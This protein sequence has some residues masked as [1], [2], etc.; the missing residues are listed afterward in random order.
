MGKLTVRSFI[1]LMAAPVALPVLLFAIVLV[2]QLDRREEIALE[3]RTMRDVNAIASAVGLILSDMESTLDL[4]A[5]APDLETGN[6]EELYFRTQRSLRDTGKFVIVVDETGRQLL[7]TRVPYDQE[8]GRTSDLESLNRALSSGETVISDVFFGQ[9]SGRHVF[10]VVKPLPA[11]EKSPARAL[12]ITKNAQELA[13]AF[14]SQDLPTGWNI[15]VTDRSGTLLAGSAGLGVGVGTPLDL[16]TDTSELNLRGI[17]RDERSNTLLGYARVPLSGWYAFIWGPIASAKSSIFA[18]WQ[19]LL[20]AGTLTL[21]LL[22]AGSMYA[23]GQLRKAITTLAKMARSVGEGNVVSPVRSRIREI[24]M[25][26]VALSEASFDRSEAEE[27]SRVVMHELAH[28]TKNLLAV[29]NSI[30]RQTARHSDSV[31][32]MQTSLQARVI[33]LA[34]S[35]DLL[36]RG[37][38]GRVSLRELVETQR[39]T[40]S[41]AAGSVG[42]EGED[43]YLKPDAAQQ[44]GM[45][46]HE[47]S[48][49]AIKYGA[50]SVPQGRVSISWNVTNAAD[51]EPTL[52]L[53]WKETGGPAVAEPKRNG[54]GQ[55]VIKQHAEAVFRGKVTMTY[56]PAGFCWTLLAPLKRLT[57]MAEDDGVDT[58]ALPD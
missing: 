49:N 57:D 56:E 13:S 12:I 1:L 53:Q 29:L 25:V 27:H 35:I 28:R 46:F 33:A 23:A 51:G 50:L 58:A 34:A 9:T 30:I 37:E 45:T 21:I 55:T 48:T 5:S 39:K 3:T 26:A 14:G 52:W 43:V 8:L 54:F 7:N 6:L 16:S 38:L 2:N 40:F 41:Q 24:D 17:S 10:N 32:E 42:V 15:A 4:V 20:A 31:A 18:N 44:L 47:L 19:L 11:F 36:T 22:I